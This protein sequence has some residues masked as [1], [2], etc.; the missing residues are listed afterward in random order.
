M[1]YTIDNSHT[2][3]GVK[4]GPLALQ[5][6]AFPLLPWPLLPRYQ[7]DKDEKY[8]TWSAPLVSD[9]ERKKNILANFR[10]PGAFEGQE[11]LV[12]VFVVRERDDVAV[13]HHLAA[14]VADHA[15]PE[16]EV[17][18]LRRSLQPTAATTFLS[19]LHQPDKP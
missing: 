14:A 1:Y 15:K 3:A 6:T 13:L 12:E 19:R 2:D 16:T 17:E 11:A 8:L 10:Q 4:P 5:V 9:N 7:Q 18:M